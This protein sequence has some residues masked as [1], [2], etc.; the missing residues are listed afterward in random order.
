MAHESEDTTVRFRVALNE[1]A[2]NEVT[3]RYETVHGTAVAGEDYESVSDVLTFAVGE[4]EKWVEVPLIDDTVEDGGETFGLRLSEVTGAML[5]DAEAVGTILN[6]ETPV[7]VPEPDGMD[8]AADATTAGS[9]VVGESVTGNV[10]RTGDKDWFAVELEA[11]TTYRIDLEG[12]PTSRGTLGD[13]LLGGIMNAD[14]ELQSGTSNDNR[15]SGNNSRT[16]FTPMESGKYYVEAAGSGNGTGTY[17]LST[18]ALTESVPEPSGTDFSADTATE[19]WI[20]VG[21]PVTGNLERSGDF[22]WFAVELKKG[23]NYRFDLEGS[24]TGAGT[25]SDPYLWG[26]RDADGYLLPGTT[27]DNGGV[28]RNSRVFFTPDADGTY[29]V[30]AGS[31]ASYW[32]GTYKLSVT[33]FGDDFSADS[34]TTGTVSVGGSTTGELETGSDVDWFAVTLE[35]D[36]AYEIRLKGLYSGAGSLPDPYLHGIYDAD[37]TFIAGTANDDGG[38]GGSRVVFTPTEAGTYYV[39]AGTA[40]TWSFGTYTLSVAETTDDFTGGTGTTGAVSVGGSTTGELETGGDV[41][42][43]A[44]TLEAGTRYRIDQTGVWDRDGSLREPVLKGVHDANGNHIAGTTVAWDGPYDSSRLFF[45]PAETGTYYVAAGGAEDFH[46]TYKLSVT[47]R[48]DDFLATKETTGAVSVDGWAKGELDT[49]GDSDWFAVTLEADRTYRI[50]LEGSSTHRGRLHD[51]YLRGIHDENGDFIA[52][53]RNDNGGR[54][55]NSRVTFTPAEDGTYYIATGATSNGLGTGNY[56][57]RVWDVTNG[58]PDDFAA[59]TGTVGA[60]SVGGSQTGEIET[61]GDRDWFAVTLEADKTYR[62]DLEG[63]PSGRGSLW[64]PY[65]RGIH[66]A[67]GNYISGTSDDHSGLRGESRETFTPTQTGTYYVAAGANTDYVGSYTLTVE[68]VI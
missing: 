17:T 1:A 19:G 27:N 28:I 32:K 15:G 49:V 52:G 26:I 31:W 7:S 39:A 12:S 60:V 34:D 56:E 18:K 16:Y 51:P 2:P 44:V 29:Y 14:G 20:A 9:V 36:Q 10:D 38:P 35:A 66:N 45:E 6:S 21:E 41:D 55:W 68:E 58:H 48:M 67:D 25:L 30:A 43:F 22:D 24:W 40:R 33:E 42:W 5:G 13:P 53:T 8:F 46:G 62:F 47:D 61:A 64:D 23:T 65:L 3:V 63:M 57:V 4:T 50:D 11:G 54:N 37:S 59:D